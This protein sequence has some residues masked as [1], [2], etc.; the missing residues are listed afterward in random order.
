M[1]ITCN[2]LKILLSLTLLLSLHNF[3]T[4]PTFHMEIFGVSNPSK[5]FLEIGRNYVSIIITIIINITVLV[6]HNVICFGC[7]MRKSHSANRNVPPVVSPLHPSPLKGF[8]KVCLLFYKQYFINIFSLWSDYCKKL[9]IFKVKQI[10]SF[11]LLLVSL[12]FAVLVI[13]VS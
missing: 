6:S 9:C 12:H 7:F 3:K 5:F 2:N 13:C 11:K 8:Q 1:V 10:F 4:L